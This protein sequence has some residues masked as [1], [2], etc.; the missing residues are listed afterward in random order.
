MM[1]RKILLYTHAMV[2]GGAERVLAL[3]ASGFI[4]RGHEVILAADHQADANETYIDQRVRRVTLPPGHL[5]AVLGLARLLRVEKPAVSLSA[6]GVSN[7]KHVCAALLAGRQSLAI[8][9]YHGHVEAEPQFLSALGNRLTPLLTRFTA[10]TICVSEG[11]K[12]HVVDD[13]GA[14]AARTIVIHNPVATERARPARDEAELARRDLIVLALG[15]LDPIK[16]FPL[17]VRAFARAGVENSRLVIL[18]EGAERSAVEA[19]IA[20]L[21][22]KDRVELPGYVAEPWDYFIKARVLAISSRSETFGNAAVEALAHGLAVVATDSMGPHEIL[23]APETGTLVPVGDET[24]LAGAIRAALLNPG[25]PAPR[26]RRAEEFS[27]ET[28]IDRYEAL[29]EEIDRQK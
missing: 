8:L 26:V 4:R 3:L 23:N 16:Q 5:Q 18:G 17:L 21:G 6:I 12:R 1:P 14:S 22:L 10:R 13:L 28:A 2:G 7:L 15:R 27:V 25:D 11:L 24:A 19:E 20:R 29:F 9:S